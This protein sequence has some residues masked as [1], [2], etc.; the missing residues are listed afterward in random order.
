MSCL[1][2]SY[3]RNSPLSPGGKIISWKTKKA[4]KPKKLKTSITKIHK[5]FWFKLNFE[6]MIFLIA[7]M[8]A[9]M[10]TI[11]MTERNNIVE[12]PRLPISINC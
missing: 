6:V 7:I 9:P 1:Q 5:I 3:H 4:T 12:T 10:T 11:T 2:G 8:Y